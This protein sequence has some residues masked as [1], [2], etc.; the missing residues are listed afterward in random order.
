M[1][2]F[3]AGSVVQALVAALFVSAYLR[4][5]G[6]RSPSERLR[7]RLLALAVPLLAHPAFSLLPYRR[8]EDFLRDGALFWAGRWEA[9]GPA[10]ARLLGTAVAGMAVLSLALLV[11][12]L[13]AARRR[14][15]P[16]AAWGTPPPAL[17]ARVLSLAE[18]LEVP[19]PLLLV[20]DSREPSLLCQGLARPRLVVSQ[21]ALAGLDDRALEGALAH[22]LA[23]LKGRDLL[24]GWGL[25][26]ARLLL[27]W[28]PVV[29]VLGRKALHDLEERADALSA[30]AS[31]PEAVAAALE[32]LS[33][34]HA[35]DGSPLQEA[36]SLAIRRRLG[37]LLDGAPARPASGSGLRLGT[38]AAALIV[39]L[40]FVA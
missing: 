34:R 28:N 16:P 30:E 3:L 37:R 35:L 24:W 21:G 17:R 19:A 11:R 7:F 31:S 22:E 13:L 2:G 14:R 9:A 39:L 23:H 40:A 29:Q 15:P 12:D 27:A 6:V 32:R 1:T 4:L 38:A 33:P 20:S 18:R 8:D 5:L 36:G 26:A 25:L 10:G